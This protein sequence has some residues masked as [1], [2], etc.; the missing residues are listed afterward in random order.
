[1]VYIALIKPNISTKGN[2]SFHLN[3]TMLFMGDLK[4]ITSMLALHKSVGVLVRS[5]HLTHRMFLANEVKD[6]RETN[7]AYH[8]CGNLFIRT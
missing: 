1:M 8:T 3:P 2:Y 5:V 6:G 7:R 4:K